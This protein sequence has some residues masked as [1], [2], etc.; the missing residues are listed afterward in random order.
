M[1]SA[2]E[3]AWSAT[4]CIGSRRLV[5]FLPKLVPL[6]ERHGHLTLTDEVRRLLLSVSPATADRLLRRFRQPHGIS[7]TKRGRLLKSRWVGWASTGWRQHLLELDDVASRLREE[8]SMLRREN[9]P[10]SIGPFSL[11]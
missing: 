5:P 8:L 2:L 10:F 1:Q 9:R 7:T 6:L 3:I 4:N 11:N